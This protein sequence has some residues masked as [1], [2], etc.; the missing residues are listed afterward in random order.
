MFLASD[1]GDFT[2]SD[3]LAVPGPPV[4]TSWEGDVRCYQKATAISRRH[5]SLSQLVVLAPSVQS[6][7]GA[8]EIRWAKLFIFLELKH[9]IGP[10]PTGPMLWV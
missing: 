8:T 5:K 1:S 7:M 10:V 3:P 2:S 9:A 6:I 4:K